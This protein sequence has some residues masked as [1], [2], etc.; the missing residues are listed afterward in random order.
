MAIM[1]SH[2]SVHRFNHLLLLWCSA[3]CA[4]TKASKFTQPGQDSQHHH[5]YGAKLWTWTRFECL[6]DV[7]W[8]IY[9]YKH[10]VGKS[11]SQANLASISYCLSQCFFHDFRIWVTTSDLYFVEK[12]FCEYI[13]L[14]RIYILYINK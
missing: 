12:C 8:L 10:L 3:Q 14:F 2:F 6:N 7:T 9:W 4:E 13:S 1:W 5:R 11:S